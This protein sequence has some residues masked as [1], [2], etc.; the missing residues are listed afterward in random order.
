MN[1]VKE[2]KQANQLGGQ[3]THGILIYSLILR[4]VNDKTDLKYRIEE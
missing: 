2:I 4:F 3:D 1:K